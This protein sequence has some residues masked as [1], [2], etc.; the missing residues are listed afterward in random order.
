MRSRD[1]PQIAQD[2]F[3]SR[4]QQTE[5]L[6]K[7]VASALEGQIAS[8]NARIAGIKIPASNVVTAAPSPSVV[9]YEFTVEK[10]EDG[11]VTKIHAKA[12]PRKMN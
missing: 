6:V 7:S 3:E 4:L 9:D 11:S 10:D 8:V 5:A 1:I 12:I 2:E